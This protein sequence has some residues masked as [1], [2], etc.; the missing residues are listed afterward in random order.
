MTLIQERLF[1]TSLAYAWLFIYIQDPTLQVYLVIRFILKYSSAFI[2]IDNYAR[3]RVRGY[4][5][6]RRLLYILFCRV[7]TNNTFLVNYN[8]MKC[9]DYNEINL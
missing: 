4:Y 6:T 5:G 1:C 7:P 8:N 2:L 3:C 9:V